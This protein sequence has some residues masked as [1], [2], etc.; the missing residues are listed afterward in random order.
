MVTTS[1]VEMGALHR[2]DVLSQLAAN[3][4]RCDTGRGPQVFPDDDILS[5]TI[6][7]DGNTSVTSLTLL[8]L[9]RAFFLVSLV[10]SPCCAFSSLLLP[11]ATSHQCV[12][13]ERAMH[14]VTSIRFQESKITQRDSLLYFVCLFKVL[15]LLVSPLSLGRPP[16]IHPSKRPCLFE[17]PSLPSDIPVMSGDCDCSLQLQSERYE[18]V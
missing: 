4:A 14:T 17:L 13:A 15:Y 9:P 10:M 3:D 2:P 1:V 18:S 11:L 6:E 5:H 8:P 7:I 16:R 12:G